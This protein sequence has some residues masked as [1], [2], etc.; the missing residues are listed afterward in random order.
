MLI[1]VFVSLRATFCSI[2][3]R[4]GEIVRQ[5]LHARDSKELVSIS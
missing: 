4:K 1:Y 2:W 5:Y 3:K